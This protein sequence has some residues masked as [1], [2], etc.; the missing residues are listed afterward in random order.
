M[1]TKPPREN[2]FQY[3]RREYATAKNFPLPY[4]LDLLYIKCTAPV[5]VS[6]IYLC[7]G[8][9]E[10]CPKLHHKLFLV[11]VEA[12]K[13]YFKWEYFNPCLILN[14]KNKPIT[15][16]SCLP[17][18]LENLRNPVRYII[19]IYTLFLPSIPIPRHNAMI[20]GE[21]LF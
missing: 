12:W 16:L 1:F 15:Y 9:H 5:Q 2:C 11:Y 4:Y 17:Y 20:W 7:T 19:K 3:V 13:L 21:Q 18:G 8:T 14:D 6:Q 10:Q